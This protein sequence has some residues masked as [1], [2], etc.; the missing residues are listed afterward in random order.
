MTDNQD[1]EAGLERAALAFIGTWPL[2]YYRC[3]WCRR[4]VVTGEAIAHQRNCPERPSSSEEKA[5]RLDPGR[6]CYWQR[7]SS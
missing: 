7:S 6:N 5:A 2:E 3:P 4:S 1:T